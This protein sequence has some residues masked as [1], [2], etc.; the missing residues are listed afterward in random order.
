MSYIPL[1]KFNSNCSKE[2]EEEEEKG[3]FDIEFTGQK[4][5]PEIM[6][7]LLTLDDRMYN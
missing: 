1:K 6:K 3:P 5:D 2:N 7:T 4:T